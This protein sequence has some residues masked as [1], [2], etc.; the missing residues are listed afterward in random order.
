MKRKRLVELYYMLSAA[1]FYDIDAKELV[2]GAEADEIHKQRGSLYYKD[3]YFEG[4]PD[5]RVAIG[6]DYQPVVN[7]CVWKLKE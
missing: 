4:T 3:G 1:M 2:R 6:N 5:E 7:G